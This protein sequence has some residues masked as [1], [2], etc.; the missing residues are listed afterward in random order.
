MLRSRRR[1]LISWRQEAASLP[2]PNMDPG[3]DAHWTSAFTSLGLLAIVGNKSTAKDTNLM[4]FMI[5][6]GAQKHVSYIPRTQNSCHHA[7][8]SSC[9]LVVSIS[10]C[11]NRR[12]HS[13]ALSGFQSPLMGSQAHE[14]CHHFVLYTSRGFSGWEKGVDLRGSLGR[15]LPKYRH[16]LPFSRF[17]SS[18]RG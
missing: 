12:M 17:Y 5:M 4:V 2:P 8:A 10:R 14:S 6:Y 3:P 15:S 11:R 7:G 9:S 16:R 13:S 18:E 1:L